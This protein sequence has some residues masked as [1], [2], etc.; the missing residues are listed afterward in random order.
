VLKSNAIIDVTGP[1]QAASL[2]IRF[3]T[4]PAKLAGIAGYSPG[5]KRLFDLVYR[6]IACLMEGSPTLQYWGHLR[7]PFSRALQAN[8]QSGG[9]HK[10]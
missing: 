6:H 7:H 10:A 3:G 8:P 4:V 1:V 5:Y 9:G 2:T